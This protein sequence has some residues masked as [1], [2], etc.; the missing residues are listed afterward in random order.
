MSVAPKI[1][2]ILLCLHTVTPSLQNL[3]TDLQNLQQKKAAPHPLD[4]PAKLDISSSFMTCGIRS[5]RFFRVLSISAATIPLFKICAV[6][7]KFQ[8]PKCHHPLTTENPFVSVKESA[9]CLRLGSEFLRPRN[10]KRSKTFH[11]R[12]PIGEIHY[13]FR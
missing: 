11:L 9:S 1:R 2:Q 5:H 6:R 10:N 7:P 4:F 13:L 12:E 8:L 3:R